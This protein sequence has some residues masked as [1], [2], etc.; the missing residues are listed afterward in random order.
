MA[1]ISTVVTNGASTLYIYMYFF[2]G[3]QLF[4]CLAKR[5]GPLYNGLSC[6]SSSQRLGLGKS[7]APIR[8]DLI[9]KVCQRM[10]SKVSNNTNLLVQSFRALNL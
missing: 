5:A 4:D 3:F 1:T 2:S 7:R 10:E 8:H 9:H 6:R